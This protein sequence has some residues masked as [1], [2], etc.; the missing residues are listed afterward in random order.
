MRNE[1]LENLSIKKS[2]DGGAFCMLRV[3]DDLVVSSDVVEEGV[4]N[5]NGSRCQ[6]IVVL[7][8]GGTSPISV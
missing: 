5:S 6:V 2:E 1:E 4:C 3:E 7:Q 8:K